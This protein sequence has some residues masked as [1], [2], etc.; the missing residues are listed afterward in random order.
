MSTGQ[1]RAWSAQDPSVCGARCRIIDF[2]LEYIARLEQLDFGLGRVISV[3]S[4]LITS[5]QHLGAL[6]RSPDRV[7]E[8]REALS[9]LSERV[10]ENRQPATR[11]SRSGPGGVRPKKRPGPL[12]SSSQ[13]SGQRL[14]VDPI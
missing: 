14:N 1:T 6:S 13:F 11:G 10:S 8:H 12:R 5:F 4:V 2:C 9:L 3:W 7:R